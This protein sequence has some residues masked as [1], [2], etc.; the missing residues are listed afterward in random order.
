MSRC[1]TKC[2]KGEKFHEKNHICRIIVQGDLDKVKKLVDKPK[3][4]CKN[5]G[6]AANDNVNICKPT[7]L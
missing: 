2:T 5:C 3:Y 6:R 1:Q 4:I 7:K